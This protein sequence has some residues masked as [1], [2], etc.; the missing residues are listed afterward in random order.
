MLTK[1]AQTMPQFASLLVFMSLGIL[2]TLRGSS[3]TVEKAFTT[4]AILKL[5]TQPLE[6]IRQ[7]PRM[8]QVITSMKRIQEF[9][10]EDETV[11]NRQVILCSEN[12]DEKAA[13]I[14][15]IGT[16][17]S[18]DGASS[19]FTNV[20]GAINCGSFNLILGPVG[21]GK[22]TLLRLLIGGIS[23]TEGLVKTGSRGM[24]FC[25][26][27]AWL[28]NGTLKENIAVDQPFQLEWF[29]LVVW[30]CCLDEDI[31][32]LPGGIQSSVGDEGSF[33]SGGQ[34]NR[35]VHTREIHKIIHL[36]RFLQVLA[37][38]IYSR[39]R[40]IVLDDV[41][42]GLDNRIARILFHRVFGASG[43][44]KQCGITA[45]LATN[46][47]MLIYAYRTWEYL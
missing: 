26:Q 34:K 23:A 20:T 9:L 22:S 32:A 30:A 18:Y 42:A 11:D 27:D 24:A 21:S 29:W 14:Q 41:L 17:Y 36:T 33:L 16:G 47:S 44:L 6:T 31:D 7:V 15:L 35:M 10:S 19:V 2:L 25:G 45:I 3:L 40:V 37:R 39:R 1:S 46:D 12:S 8:V 28:F 4:L 5:F 43:I 38:A 13:I